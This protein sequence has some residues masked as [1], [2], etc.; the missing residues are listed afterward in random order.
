MREKEIYCKELSQAIVESDK[1]QDLKLASQSPKG[2]L[3]PS[4][5]VAWRLGAGINVPAQRQSVRKNSLFWGKVNLFVP[6]GSLFDWMGLTHS[7]EVNLI[8]LIYPFK[9]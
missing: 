1:S 5:P 9:C 6:P 2:T 7:R 8:Y 3:S 4:E